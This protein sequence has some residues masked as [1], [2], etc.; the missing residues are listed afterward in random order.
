M[1]TINPRLI[2]GVLMRLQPAKAGAERKNDCRALMSMTQELGSPV[3]IGAVAYLNSR[4]L[5]YGLP[6]RSPPAKLTVDLPSRLADDLAAGRLDVALIPSIE[7]FRHV[8]YTIVSDACVACDGPVLSVKLYSRVPVERIATLALDEGSR[9]SA[10]LTRLLLAERFGVYPRLEQLPIGATI[11][12][13]AA[14]AVTLIGDRAIREPP[15]HFACTWDLGEEWTRWTGLPMV[16]A[17]WVARPDVDL[18]HLS[19]ALSASRDQG[20]RHLADIARRESAVLDLPEDVCLRY[21]RDHLHFDL[22]PRQR[23]GLETFYRLAVQYQ[24]APPGVPLVF[25]D[26]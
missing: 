4:P 18:D 24:L 7:Y 16:F 5:V 23:A 13:C 14:D 11:D 21:L 20:M 6:P 9:T 3:R 2:M 1:A 12:D 25:Y 8:G 26:R 17:M 19:N 15:G 10:A 22:G